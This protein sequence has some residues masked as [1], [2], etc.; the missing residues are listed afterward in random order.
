MLIETGKLLIINHEK[1]GWLHPHDDFDVRTDVRLTRGTAMIVLQDHGI[2]RT[3]A[4][5]ENKRVRK[6]E[7]LTPKGHGWVYVANLDE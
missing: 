2:T 5:G 6:L 7:V 3:W 4:D 1:G